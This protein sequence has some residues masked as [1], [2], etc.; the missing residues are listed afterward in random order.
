MNKHLLDRRQ[1]SAGCAA[2]GLSVPASTALL[3]AQAFGAEPNPGPRTVKFPDGTIVPALGQGSWHLGQG[4][5]RQAAEEEAM[6]T[7]IALGMTVID[8]SR[9]YGDGRSERFIG[10]VI[11]GQRDKVFLVSKV[12]A[13]EI[14]TGAAANLGAGEQFALAVRTDVISRLCDQSL[15]R[16]GTNYLDLYLLHS[17]VP[18]RFVSGVV[19][20][21]E[22]L[23]AAGKIRAWGVSNHNVQQM[24]RLFGVP[25]GH[26]CAT[27][28][29]RYSLRDRQ[30]EREILPWCIEHN[31]P[32]MA[33]SPLGGIEFAKTLLGE[34]TLKEL[35]A[36]HGVS[37]AAVAL[38][39]VMR[40]GN[41]IAIPES[42]NPEH[43][44]ENAAALNIRWIPPTP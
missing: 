13:D 10:R 22:E 5:H 4:R 42:G 16:L 1:F 26:R 7:G 17:P 27:N 6:R 8:T 41:V 38:A 9:N 19:A 29:W 32:M 24:E 43:V 21:F 3:A 37:P 11:A 39:F 31:M 25:D 18:A 33:A 15:S 28:Q 20:K 35:G 34:R 36:A 30:I 44:K 23:R 12:Q 14:E 40:S 2:F